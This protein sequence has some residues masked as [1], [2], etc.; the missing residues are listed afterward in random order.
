M[1]KQFKR[2]LAARGKVEE[3]ERQKSIRQKE[4]ELKS[5]HYLVSLAAKIQ[6]G[7]LRLDSTQ[8]RINNVQKYLKEALETCTK[9]ENDVRVE[10][11]S[12]LTQY[13]QYLKWCLLE[14]NAKRKQS[15]LLGFSFKKVKIPEKIGDIK[16]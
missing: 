10:M 14:E 15:P 2:S 8:L 16:L 13:S 11:E 7:E 1:V 9:K 4:L 6:I 5:K 12:N 3:Q